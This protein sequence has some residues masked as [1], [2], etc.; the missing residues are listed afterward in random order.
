MAIALLTDFGLRDG[1]VGMMKGVMA[2]IAPR[3]QYID[4]THMIPPQDVWA[5]RFCLGNAVCCFPA[6]T[7][8]LGVVDPGVGS[9]RRGIA[10]QFA[11]GYFV[12]PDNGLVSGIL[13]QYEAIAAVTLTNPRY[14]RTQ[15]LNAISSTFHGRDIF[16][17][18]AAHLA[19]GIS[20][21]QLG[22]AIDP[23]DLV[24]LPLPP[25]HQQQQTLTGIIQYIDH[26][27]N[28]VSN[29]PAEAILSQPGQVLY[30]D[31]PIP[32]VRTYSDVPPQ[33]PCA[34]IGSHGWL[35]ISLN[36]GN[37]QIIFQAQRGDTVQFILT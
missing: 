12:G 16:A 5:G 14:W 2:G 34:L 31:R 13:D 20:L 9:A 4:L 7:V 33:Q 21:Q 25:V 28:L 3:V 1:Y 30:G 35:E 29:I 17:P 18:V 27:G 19:T 23:Q 8:F 11:G 22:A 36:Q 26:F 6:G 24:T 10:V 15:T 32:Y 37:A